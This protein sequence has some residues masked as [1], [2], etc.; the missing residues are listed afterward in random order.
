MS[1]TRPL[2]PELPLPDWEET[3]NT[4]HLWVQIVGKIRMGSTVP[5]NH[6]WHVPLYLDVRGL[7]TRR[8][9]GSDGLTFEIV[10]DFVDH[11]LVIATN[12]GAV[13]S[14]EL[15]DGLSVAEFDEKLDAILT[16]LGID[17]TIRETP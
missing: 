1:K 4:L 17:V 3:K 5:R 12:S 14:F 11:R 2:L 15:A 8:L 9:H 7:T 13:E 6:W 10:F 16:R